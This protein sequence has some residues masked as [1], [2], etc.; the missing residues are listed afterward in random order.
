M[1][2][3]PYNAI[4]IELRKSGVCGAELNIKIHGRR[5]WLRGTYHT[6]KGRFNFNVFFF[7]YLI[8]RRI[9]KTTAKNALH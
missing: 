7:L 6:G 8:L 9:G 1:I 4:R 2:L 5:V 3:H